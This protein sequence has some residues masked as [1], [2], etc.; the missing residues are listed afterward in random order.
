M[1]YRTEQIYVLFIEKW[2]DIYGGP[3]FCYRGH[4]PRHYRT[5]ARAR[6][7][8]PV[9]PEVG[10]RP[11][12]SANKRPLAWTPPIQVSAAK[13]KLAPRKCF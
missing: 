9:A 11:G 1:C 6:T 7:T 2:G 13:S 4:L 12:P 10:A 5:P 8:T 3:F